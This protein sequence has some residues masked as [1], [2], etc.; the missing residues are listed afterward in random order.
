M[1][2]IL[3]CSVPLYYIKASIGISQRYKKIG[4]SLL[5]TQFG[6]I[7]LQSTTWQVNRPPT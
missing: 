1:E 3:L 4:Q 5:S 7:L 6:G 2:E